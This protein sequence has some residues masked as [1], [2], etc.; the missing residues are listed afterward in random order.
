MQPIEDTICRTTKRTGVLESIQATTKTWNRRDRLNEKPNWDLLEKHRKANRLSRKKPIRTATLEFLRLAWLISNP[1]EVEK[2]SR[3]K[4]KD[5][6]EKEQMNQEPSFWEKQL[7]KR[8]ARQW[9]V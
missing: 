2:Q 7:R 8:E 5:V 9:R 1:V 3:E 4:A 6:Y